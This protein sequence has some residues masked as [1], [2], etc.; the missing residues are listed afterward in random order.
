MSVQIDD[1]LARLSASAGHPGLEGL[2]DRVLGAIGRE[3]TRAIGARATLGAAAFS[4]LLGG[5]SNVVPAADAQ[6]AAITSPFGA[7]NPLAPSTLL[8]G[9]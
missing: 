8:I 4:L 5:I 3:S 6:A 9:R 1:A 2:E 7:S